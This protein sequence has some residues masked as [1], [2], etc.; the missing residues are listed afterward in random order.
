MSSTVPIATP[1]LNQAPRPALTHV[2]I[3]VFDG[4][5]RGHQQVVARLIK[6]APTP[7][8]TAIITFEPHPLHIIAPERAPSRLTNAH[9]KRDLLLHA[10]VAEVIT[11]AF[12]RTTR[13]LSASDFIAELLRI[14]PNLRA[15]GMGPNWSFGKDRTG[16]A[17]LLTAVGL[18]KGFIV[19][20]IPPLVIEGQAASSTRIR[21]AIAQRDFALAAL[22]L[23]RSY[24]IE[25][26][27][28][29]GDGRG[30]TLGFPTANLTRV[31][32][33]LPPPGVYAC[34]ARLSDRTVA[35]VLNI[36]NRPTFG[37]DAGFSV[38]A[39]LIHFTGDLYD[40]TLEL[41]DFRFLREEKRFHSVDDLKN[42]IALDIVS[43]LG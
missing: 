43:A 34:T 3:G 31:F 4:F 29:H 36:G 12:D 33:M 20:E 11:L 23:G 30:Q 32:Q 16:N 26:R 39:H 6:D 14:L 25:G 1:L 7:G 24:A 13:E 2:A 18:E 19:H 35:A 9:Q 38:E 8:S 5:H 40:Q 42:Q 22:L 10:G 28:T 15:I 37:A 27:V 17:A 41:A 21:E